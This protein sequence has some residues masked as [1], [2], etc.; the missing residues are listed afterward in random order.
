MSELADRWNRSGSEFLIC[1]HAPRNMIREYKFKVEFLKQLTMRMTGGRNESHECYIYRRI[2]GATSDEGTRCDEIFLHPWE[3]C[4]SGNVQALQTHVINE[5]KE[6]SQMLVSDR[7]RKAPK[8]YSDTSW[9]TKVVKKIKRTK[10]ST[11]NIKRTTKGAKNI[12]KIKQTKKST[13]NI[14][15]TKKGAKN[16]NH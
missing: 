8:I 12:K 7:S 16:I 4:R 13:K 3:M 9:S 5:L 6:L 15:R 14:K 1:Y 11:K 2:Q 10:K